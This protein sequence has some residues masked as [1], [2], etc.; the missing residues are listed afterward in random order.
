MNDVRSDN[1]DS[2]I[3]G[4][5]RSCASKPKA[6]PANRLIRPAVSNFQLA[7]NLSARMPNPNEAQNA[8][9]AP[10]ITSPLNLFISA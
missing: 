2:A 5:F 8:P 1:E 7:I 9:A 3:A 4:K 6:V 10:A